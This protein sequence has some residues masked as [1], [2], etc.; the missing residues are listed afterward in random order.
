MGCGL[1]MLAAILP[2]YHVT[3]IIVGSAFLTTILGVR[4]ASPTSCFLFIIFVND[5][6]TAMKEKFQPEQLLDWL[7]ILVLMDDTVLLSTSRHYD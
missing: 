3:E 2:M 5:L 1:V 7:H 4:Q 6:I